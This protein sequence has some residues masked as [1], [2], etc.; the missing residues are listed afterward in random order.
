MTARP[1]PELKIFQ[2]PFI[3]VLLQGWKSLDLFYPGPT[4]TADTA[5]INYEP[6]RKQKFLKALFLK[7][8]K[9]KQVYQ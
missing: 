1:I 5:E 8:Y 6:V 3:L 2:W 9:N 7:S 4:T